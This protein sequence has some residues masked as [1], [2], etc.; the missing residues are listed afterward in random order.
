MSQRYVII[1]FRFHCHQI[2]L[3]WKLTFPQA[4][5]KICDFDDGQ[6]DNPEAPS[7]GSKY[8]MGNVM[9]SEKMV[10]LANLDS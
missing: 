6:A 8:T 9:K 1:T 4:F 5:A 3:E 7:E 2:L 10:S